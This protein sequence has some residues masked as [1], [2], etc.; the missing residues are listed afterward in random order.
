MDEVMLGV[1]YAGILGLIGAY[2]FAKSK[3]A[4]LFFWAFAVSVYFVYV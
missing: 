4:A 2:A 3:W 1:I